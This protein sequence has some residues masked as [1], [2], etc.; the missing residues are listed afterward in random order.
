MI[1]WHDSSGSNA[2]SVVDQNVR[3]N[4]N[5]NQ[6]AVEDDFDNP[7]IKLREIKL[8]NPNNPSLAYINVN[9]IRNKHS[10]LFTFLDSNIDILTI[11]EPKL[12]C[13]FP[14]AQFNVEG[15]KE[16]FRKDRNK[17]GGRLVCV[18][19]DISSLELDCTFPTA[20]INVEGYKEPF[21]KDRNKNGG[22]LLVYIKKDI[23]SV[24]LDCTFPT[25]QFNVEGYKEPFRKDR[26]KNGGGPRVYVKEDIPSRELKN[27]PPVPDLLDIAVIEL[28]FRKQEMA[29]N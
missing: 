2:P 15:Y 24:E 22:G 5:V 7:A 12:D 1:R 6:N 27:H 20:Q 23:P 26:N 13:T 25:V 19:E 16:P 28:N 21:R 29:V 8:K 11:A 18:K 9:S 14:T 4:V 10:D 3:T 17:N